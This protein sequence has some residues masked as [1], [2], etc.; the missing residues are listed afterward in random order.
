[1][2]DFDLSKSPALAAMSAFRGRS[3]SG[4]EFPRMSGRSNDYSIHTVTEELQE[5]FHL[6]GDSD[7]EDELDDF[8]LDNE[9]PTDRRSSY[10]GGIFDLEE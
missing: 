1:V 7:E 10:D 5:H 2:D 3:G 8:S 9:R 6:D 4:R